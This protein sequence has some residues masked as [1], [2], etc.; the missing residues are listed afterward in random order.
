MKRLYSDYVTQA[1][2]RL[3]FDGEWFVFWGGRSIEEN[4]HAAV[5][6]Q[7]F[8]Y[9]FLVLE[10]GVSHTGDGTRARGAR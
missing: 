2:L 8:A 6:D 3:P 10:D 4:Y 1:A 7:R 9:D 5:A